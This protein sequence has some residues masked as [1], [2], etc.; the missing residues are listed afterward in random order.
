[1][2]PLIEF[3]PIILRVVQAAPQLQQ[4]LR[5]GQPALDDSLATTP[6]LKAL[7]QQLGKS[8]FPGIADAHTSLARRRYLIRLALNGCN[9]RSTYSVLIRSS[10]S[11]EAMGRRPR[12]Q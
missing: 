6:E 9:S 8:Q 4:A 1:M 2:L 11:M 3:L 10:W 12:Q 5:L 7:L